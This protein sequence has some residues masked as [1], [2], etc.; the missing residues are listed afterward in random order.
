MREIRPSSALCTA[1][2]HLDTAS[3]MSLGSCGC[4]RLSPS[5]PPPPMIPPKTPSRIAG[6]GDVDVGA[7][8]RKAPEDGAADA[9]ASR[10]AM[11]VQSRHPRDDDAANL[12]LMFRS[13][14]P[15]D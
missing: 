6:D 8:V 1:D 2:R 5:P 3:L 15:S 10:S 7:G 12:G 9:A 13:G 11:R 14:I 4:S